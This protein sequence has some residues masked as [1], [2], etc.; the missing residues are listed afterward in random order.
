M[1]FRSLTLRRLRSRNDSVMPET[2]H[3]LGVESDGEIQRPIHSVHALTSQFY[4]SSSC[5]QYYLSAILK[6]VTA[7]MYS[8]YYSN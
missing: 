7:P 2:V 1:V 6:Q 3:L 4:A 5:T 8:V